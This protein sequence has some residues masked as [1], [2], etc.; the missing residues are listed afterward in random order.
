VL[1]GFT[2]LL[3]E[4]HGG[5]LK[6]FSLPPADHDWAQFIFGCGIVSIGKTSLVALLNK[7]LN[8]EVF[9]EVFK[10]ENVL[11]GRYYREGEKWCLPMQ[12][13]FL[14]NSFHNIYRLLKLKKHRYG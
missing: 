5:T 7:K 11:L 10:D 14:S 12:I 1:L 4:H 8:L 6:E 9:P 2:G 3:L 13:N